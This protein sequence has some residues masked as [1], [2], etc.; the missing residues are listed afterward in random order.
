MTP[1]A[2]NLNVVVQIANAALEGP[3]LMAG[4][5]NRDHA[6]I[7]VGLRSSISKEEVV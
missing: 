7:A 5:F 6:Q 4:A 3:L 1:C 2:Q